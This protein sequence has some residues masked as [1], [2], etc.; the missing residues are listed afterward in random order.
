MMD[1]AVRLD[2]VEMLVLDEADHMLDLGFIVPIRRI[3]GATPAA[4]QTLFFSATMPKEIA[5]LAG[6]M[7]KDPVHVAVAPEARRRSRRSSRASCS[8]KPRASAMCCS[9]CCA[10]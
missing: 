7:L 5:N 3:V 10:M 8:W 6:A 2:A 4:R 9:T 1:R